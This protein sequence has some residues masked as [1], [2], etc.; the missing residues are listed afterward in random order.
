MKRVISTTQEGVDWQGEFFVASK[1]VSF[2]LV[3]IKNSHSN[4][5]MQACR[6]A[7]LARSASALKFGQ[8]EAVVGVHT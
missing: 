2:D 7:A 1:V 3:A 6:P 8:V 5:S 4:N